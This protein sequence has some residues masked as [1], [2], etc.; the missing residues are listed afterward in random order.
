MDILNECRD[1]VNESAL[2]TQNE[3]AKF[4]QSQGKKQKSESKTQESR[5]QN[6]TCAH[7]S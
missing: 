3:D 7:S 5:V 4:I 1:I 2:K 6:E